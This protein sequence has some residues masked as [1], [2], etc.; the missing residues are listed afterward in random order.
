MNDAENTTGSFIFTTPLKTPAASR[1]EDD[2]G[3]LRELCSVCLSPLPQRHCFD[4]PPGKEI[5]STNCQVW[6]FPANA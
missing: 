2:D 3:G 5:V 1:D 6:L 4:I